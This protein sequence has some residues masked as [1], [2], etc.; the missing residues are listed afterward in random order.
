MLRYDDLKTNARKFVSLTSLM[1]IEF[2][3]LLPAFE[4][5]DL[6]KHPVTKTMMGKIRKRKTGADN[7]FKLNEDDGETLITNT[8]NMPSP[9][10]N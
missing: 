2:E 3:S 1:P 6:K 8:A 9:I 5:A 4:T 10:W 7:K